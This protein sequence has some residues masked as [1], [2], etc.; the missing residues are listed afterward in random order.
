ML[1]RWIAA[2]MA[3]LLLYG[4]LSSAAP[5]A[6]QAE[7][8]AADI[9]TKTWNVAL[10]STATASGKCNANESASAAVDGKLT[11]KWCD[12][13]AVK[14]KWLKLDLGKTYNI[15]QWIV[16]NA[17]IGE[18]ANSP[19][20]NT[21]DYRLQRSDDGTTW[22]DIDVVRNNAQTLVD[23]Q[24]PTFSAR[25]VRVYI[26]QAAY[27]NNTARLY[28]IEIYGVEADQ[29]PAAP[30][31]DLLP[32]D[33]VDP[34]INTLGDNGQTNPGPT[35]PFGL[36]SVGPD[37]DGGAFSGY[38]YQDRFL[39]GFSQ[40]RFSGVGCSGAGGNILMMPETRSFTKN[41][42][43]YKQQ[44]D[45]SSESAS[46]GYYGVTLASGVKVDLTASDNVGFHR[47]TFPGTDTGSVLVDLS[48]SYAGMVDANLKVEGSNEVS[49]MIQSKNVCG[50]GYYT[51]YYSIQFDRDFDSYSSW[52]GDSVGAVASRT[53]FNSGVWLNFNTKNSAV[54]QAK[55]GLST[56][57]VEQA[58]YERSHDIPDWDF[59]AQHQRTRSAWSD[60]LN[61]VEIKG[62][63]EENKRVFY[64]QLYHSF[65]HP[66]NVTSSSG[67][68]RAGRDENTIRQAS[69]LGEDFEYYNGWSTWDDF[70]K[71]ALYSVLD[72]KRYENMVK[73]MID[74]YSTRG[75]YVQW[76][77]GYWPS[78]T[79]RNE[80]NGAVILDAYAKG[81]TDFDAYKALQGMAVDTD[82]YTMSDSEISGKLEKAYSAYFP[83]KLAAM[84][85]D[86]T[87]YEK[88]KAIALS[89]KSLWNVNQVDEKGDKRGFFTP[90]AQTVARTDV[91]AVDK[92]AYQGNLWTYRWFV[93][94]DVGGLAD[95]MG[96]K[97]A[98]AQDLQ[99]FFAI[100]E[101]M[102]INEPDLQVPYLFNYLGHP[103]LTQYY[104][105][106][107]TTE[108]VTQKYHNHGPY[109]YPIQSRVYRDDP[110]GYLPSMDDDA[111]GM[112]SWFVYSAMGLY[113][114]NPGD[115]YFLI[116]SPI[117]DEMT[118]H[119]DGGKTF[120]IKANNVSSENRFIQ[121]AKLNG[122]DFDQAWIDYDDIMAGGTIS[123]EMG[124][125]PNTSW[126][127]AASAAPPT[128]D[129]G[130]TVDNA[131]ARQTLVPAGAEW[132]YLDKGQA[133]AIG[134]TGRSFDDSSWAAGAAPLGYDSKNYAKAKT[135]YG[136]DANNK[137][138]TTY[139]RKTFEVADPK[140]LIQLNAS[141]IRD[142]GAI[143]YLNGREI[144]RTNM[145]SGTVSYGTYANATV[146]DE[147]DVNVYTID[148]SYLVAGTNVLTAEVHQVNAT[149]SDI[150]FDLGLE[151]IVP[152]V[153]PASPTA[154][155]QDDT[156]NTFGWTVVSGFEQAK[157]Y[158]FSINGGQSWKPATANPQTVGPLAYR[159]GQVQVRVKADETRGVTSGEALL[160]DAAYTSDIQWNVYDLQ[161]DV[162][163]DGNMD[164]RVTGTLKGDYEGSAYA[165]IQLMDGN[166]QA[167][168]S[169]A[170]PVE[171][172]GF[173]VSQIFNVN[174]EKFKVNVYLVDAFDG[175]IY[176]SLWLAEPVVSEP[177]P[178]PA[179]G[180]DP[181]EQPE[182]LPDPLPIPVK[183]PLPPLDPIQPDEPPVTEPGLV[184]FESR[185]EWSTAVNTFNG[186]PL[187]TE[188]GNGGTV[189][190]NT[191]DGAW[192]AYTDV[193]LGT[194]GANH[195]TVEYA[196]P[197]AKVP[198]DSKLEV[199]LGSVDGE[200]LGT[201]ALPRTG[202]E[203]TSYKTADAQFT[204][205]VIGKQTL[206]IVMHGSTTSGLPYIGNF[207]RMTFANWK[208]R[209][210]Y[211]KLELEK[212]DAWSDS[213]NPVNGGPLKTENGKSGQQVANTF[214][215]AWLAYKHMDFG[216]EGVNQ[217]SIE[218][219]GNSTSVPAD[220]SVEVRLDSV[221]GT[222]IGKVG[223]PPTA[224]AW[225]T[226]KTVSAALTQTVTGVRDVYLV[227][228]GSTDTTYK[229]I[230]N[231]DNAAFS[232]A[233]PEQPVRTDF[234]KLELESYDAWSTALNPYNNSPLG[235]ENGKSG[236]QIKNTFNGA[237]LA[238][239]RMDFGSAG[240][241]QVSI[242]YSG[243]STS[244]PAD[245]A[246]EVRLGAPD[247]ELIGK[248]LTPPTAG[249]WGTYKT[250]TANLTKKLSGV[251]D[252]YFVLVGTSTATF[253]YIGNFDN[254][255]FALSEP[256]IN[257][258]FESRSEW[259]TDKNTFNNN[260]L[261][262]EGNNGG[263]TVG[264]TFTGAWLTYKDLEFGTLGK[265]YVDI[266]YDAPTN[267]VPADVVAEIRLN[268]KNGELV[269]TVSLPN[270][271]GGW[272][273]YKTA[274]A[275]LNRSLTGKQTLCV[276]FKGSTTSSLLYIG[277]LD[278]MIYSRKA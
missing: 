141:L 29:I 185:S 238:F 109:A 64:T 111:G 116:G 143:V 121:S 63:D 69:E 179:P 67:T 76:G 146:G 197:T 40:L 221:D 230:G 260:P 114:A 124:A 208:L 25:Y 218:Y 269:G 139:F 140:Q 220:A 88:Y 122:A 43:E 85:G 46:P 186:N 255:A 274:G 33:Y 133:A 41:S 223:A 261:K 236:K 204:K 262:T 21:K 202:T 75:S 113:P 59:E 110:E 157:D 71:Y 199:R 206:Y 213:V 125:T 20:W 190:A 61:K 19:F 15:N 92:Y 151:A 148:P 51:I 22:E 246:V 62:G 101:Y 182:P 195:I 173:E 131:L 209:S 278:R 180:E 115:P 171:A 77:D 66:K 18:S 270:T 211:A 172:G 7:E 134:W 82:N 256:D 2:A 183:P 227:L 78:P 234:A 135:S 268:D 189:V 165:V 39:K 27:D 30:A 100:D 193:D 38:Y 137:Y 91:T 198:A 174:A 1:K 188:D 177:E 55:V 162:G 142:D 232:L 271:G 68:F 152:M 191:F 12:N 34:F 53:G 130:A 11:T 112:S 65:L 52:Q 244:C 96:G 167:W 265:N 107:F 24:V 31:T 156:A 233:V 275:A 123:F 54:V 99:H 8:T 242:E 257:V 87:S 83:M 49:G 266:V 23:R 161:A 264:N 104:A 194:E 253:K 226:Y 184:Q 4:I 164:V 36:A 26:D 247:G 132:K 73:S 212:Y 252:V 170:M 224:A 192:L 147:R 159:A 3:A 222:L 201:V 94:Q 219:S 119:L 276:V 35:M 138:P 272:G 254:A 120:T 90:N 28:E 80:F 273:S 187:K 245:A 108:V 203:W 117:F 225:G 258:E 237:W 250:A 217:F 105:R 154:P 175:D 14:K 169:S 56:I 149:S 89:Y 98:M 166:D 277:N 235:T 47:Y 229:Y 207:D 74:L 58:K 150:A 60:V 93:P 81:F 6:A 79:V 37:G 84:L 200:L 16:K 57:S 95:L 239:K 178:K 160:S 215:G 42:S 9:Y 145:P 168:V 45:K 86:K 155:I 50:H 144:I 181:P 251:Q 163:R 106:E 176:N 97:Q 216:T 102:A 210:D 240:V 70:R 243:N 5:G 44:Y 205:T 249:A 128:A 263:T 48:N 231:F 10:N 248:V 136:P 259:S 103:Y 127:A 158:E 267:R 13:T 32:V 228:T 17:A 241:D 196:A 118:L 129:Y 153:K 214:D 126:G 72:P